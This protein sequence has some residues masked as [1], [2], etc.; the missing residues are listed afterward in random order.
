MAVWLTVALPN[1]A[2]LTIASRS[3]AN[4]IARRTSTSS[5]GSRFSLSARYQ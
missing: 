1:L 3:I 5:N 2:A 4:A